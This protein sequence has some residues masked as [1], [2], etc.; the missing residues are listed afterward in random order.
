LV[1][2]KKKIINRILKGFLINQGFACTVSPLVN[3]DK[4]KKVKYE[5]Y[6]FLMSLQ[7]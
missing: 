3:E 1:I 4:D 5:F 2:N 6:F 7:K